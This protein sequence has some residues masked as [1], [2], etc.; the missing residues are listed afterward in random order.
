MENKKETKKV[1]NVDEVKNKY[2][3]TRNMFIII[4]LVLAVFVIVDIIH[5]TYV[6]NKIFEKNIEI[7]YGTN[8]KVTTQTNG[9]ITEIYHKDDRIKFSAGIMGKEDRNIIVWDGEKSYLVVPKDK[10]YYEMPENSIPQKPNTKGVTFFPSIMIEK[11]NVD[12]LF[13]V[14][15]TR[16]IFNI[17]VSTEKLE[18]EKTYALK[19]GYDDMKLWFSIDDY[20][21]IREVNYGNVTSMKSE[22]DV[23]TDTDV[24]LPWELDYKKMEM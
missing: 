23:V 1:E 7:D 6:L 10:V 12:T 16:F 3:K 15:K 5:D 20:S 21:F 18:G 22:K 4:L 2:K 9:S 19:V 8:Y 17:R 14:L 24:M 11:E 13:E